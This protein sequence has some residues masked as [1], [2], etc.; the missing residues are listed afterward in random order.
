MK[1][2]KNTVTDFI[3]AF[4]KRVYF[5]DRPNGMILV[6]FGVK[7]FGEFPKET[8]N[9]FLKGNKLNPKFFKTYYV[10]VVNKNMWDKLH[11]FL[12]LSLLEK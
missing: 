3:P 9:D 4:E 6:R 8:V 11:L 5:C 10:L 7:S 2:G 12:K 1:V